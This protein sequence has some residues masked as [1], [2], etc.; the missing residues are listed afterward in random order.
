MRALPA[1]F[2][3]LHPGD[4]VKD[5]ERC[6]RWRQAGP[7]PSRNRFCRKWSW[8]SR[9]V[10]RGF[11]QSLSP[12]GPCLDDP[13]VDRDEARTLAG[14]EL[15]GGHQSMSGSCRSSSHSC[16][17]GRADVA[18]SVTSS[19]WSGISDRNSL[20]RTGSLCCRT[21]LA[22]GGTATPR[23]VAAPKSSA[24]NRS[25]RTLIP[26]GLSAGRRHRLR[27]RPT[28]YGAGTP[29]AALL[30]QGTWQDRGRR[31]HVSACCRADWLD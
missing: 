19:S 24:V 3:V 7:G 15:A 16:Q 17:A 23:K 25:R 1:L 10:H 6:H 18:G 22:S 21:Q 5:A 13:V 4:D 29:H 28:R 8:T 26:T 9:T 14:Q 12:A 20:K 31:K 2:F 30:K 27:L 11:Q